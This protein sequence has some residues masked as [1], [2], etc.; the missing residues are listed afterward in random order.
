MQENNMKNSKSLYGTGVALVTPFDEEG[1]IDFKSLRKLL[2]HTAKGVDYFV[3]MGTTGESVTL[4]KEEK[5]SVLSFVLKNNRKQLPIVYGIGGNNTQAVIEEIKST[6]LKGVDAL[7]SVSPYYNKPSQEGIYQHFMAVAKASPIPLILYNVPGRTASNLTAETTLRL[8]KNKK[9]IG[10]KE[11][12]GN[13]EQCMHIAKSKPKDF[14]LISGDDMLTLPI[15][16]IGGAGAISVLANAYPVLFK[17]IKESA[18]AGKYAKAQTELFKLLEING[19]MYEEG[20]PVGL[21]HLL[22]LMKIGNGKVRLPLVGAS[23]F[24]R[25]KIETAFR[26]I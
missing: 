6:N 23:G 22:K 13:L 15:Y 10:T 2:T 17:K 25:E 16:S 4:S 3:V 21:K 24:L 20:N 11:A 8:A 12:S 7:L 14:L 1:K 19:P 9:I 5:K 26:K 18:F